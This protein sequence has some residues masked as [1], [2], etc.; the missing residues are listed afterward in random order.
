[1]PEGDSVYQLSKRLQFMEGRE[2][3]RC[4]LRV[5]RFATVDFTGMTV[6]RVWPYGK[7]LFMQFG[8]DGHESQ[9]L[10]THLKMEGSWSIHRAG[11]RWSKPGHTAR[12]VL[13][14]VDRGGDIELVGH[15]LGLVD[16]FPARLFEAEMGYLGPDLLAPTFDI[17]EAT[18]RIL[19]DPGRE[20]GR[21]LLDQQRVAGIG[22]EYRAEI[23]FLAGVHP[24]RTVAEVGEDGV[25]NMLKIARRLMWA[26]KDEVKRVTT[27]VKRAGETTYVFGRNN[28]PCR[29]C[30][31]LI[32]Q[33]VLGG[34]GDLERVIW[35]CPSC[36]PEPGAW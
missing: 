7:H 5:P 3:T 32:T 27:G 36:Q 24:A 23:C 11:S 31:T 33:G 34:Q 15:S 20:I 16:V 12:V 22:N 8:A 35:W 17:E 19:A 4:S 10:H 26:N 9:I 21:S 28:K 29:R 13:Q 6:E 25:A 30:T 1:M 18:R 14:L 2:V